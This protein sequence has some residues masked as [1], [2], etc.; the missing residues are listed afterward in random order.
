MKDQLMHPTPSIQIDEANTLLDSLVQLRNTA[1]QRAEQLLSR[2]QPKIKR[3]AFTD[4]ARNLAHYLA[5][6]EHDL[7]SLQ[8]SLMPWGLASM[9]HIESHVED[10]LNAIIDTLE[11]LHH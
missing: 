6:R 3:T 7:R 8:V 4:G 1:H 10:G 5:L 11:A 2:W 9:G